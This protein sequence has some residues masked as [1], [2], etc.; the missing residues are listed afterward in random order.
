MED[1]VKIVLVERLN[2]L[3]GAGYNEILVDKDTAMYLLNSDGIV[4]DGKTYKIVC[5]VTSTKGLIFLF[6]ENELSYQI[7]DVFINKAIQEYK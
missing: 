4:V 7:N 3:D 6:I 1:E 2:Q 5:K